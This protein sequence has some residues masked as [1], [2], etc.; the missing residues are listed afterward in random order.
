MHPHDNAEFAGL[1]RDLVDGSLTDADMARLD[2]ILLADRGARDEYRRWMRME[3]LLECGLVGDEASPPPRDPP[4]TG[5]DDPPQRSRGTAAWNRLSPLAWAALAVAVAVL[6]GMAS[7]PRR[8]VVSNAVATLTGATDARL[9]DPL[10]GAAIEAAVGDRLASGP[11]RLDGGVV[12]LTFNDGAV[13]AMNAP[14]EVELVTDSRVFLRRGRLVPLVPPRAKGFTVLSP[15]GEIVDL[16]TEFSVNVDGSGAAEIDVIDG[17]VV[18]ADSTATDAGRRHLTLGYSANLR[19]GADLPSTRLTGVPLVID[20]F[21][22]ADGLDLNSGLA[23]RQ[24]GIL[25][26]VRWRSLENDAPAR[27]DGRALEIPFESPPGRQRTMTRAVLDRAFR[28]MVGRRWMVS[29]KVWLPPWKTTPANHWVGLILSCGDE[30]RELPFG[31]D[32]RAAVAIMVSNKWQAGIDFNGTADPGPGPSL[33]VFP[34]SDAGTGPYQVMLVVDETAPGDA[35]IDVIVNGRE[36]LRRFPLALD[37][38]HGRILGFHTWT[39]ANSGAHS[40]ARID[41]FCVSGDIA[42]GA[43]AQ[44]A[45]AAETV[46]EGARP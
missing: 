19:T 21:D 6:G 33:D 3:A 26:P 2:A 12:Q 18:V 8:A 27:I 39:H 25:G 7:V 41:D 24:S 15:G 5:H 31:W 36:L 46:D 11:L 35:L 38:G 10:T 43:D 30:P 1:M 40:H 16:G 14:A 32:E 28:E 44:P 42:T 22:A 45:A 23:E 20:H 17:E 37:R 34:R 9:V 29:F 13:V 4:T